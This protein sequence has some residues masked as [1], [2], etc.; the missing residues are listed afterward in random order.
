MVPQVAIVS[1]DGGRIRT[2]KTGCGP[3]VHLVGKGWNETKNAILVS[4]ASETSLVDPEPAPPECF[5]DPEHVAKLAEMAKTKER[6]SE[7]DALADEAKPTVTVKKP[8]RKRP[9]H[10][11]KRIHRAIISSL[12]NARQFGEQ[13]AREAKRRRFGEALRKAFVGDGLTCN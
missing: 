6:A 12:K 10:K 1:Y 9:G 7:T 3:G 8:K 13:M 5:F 2:R 4:A 11:P